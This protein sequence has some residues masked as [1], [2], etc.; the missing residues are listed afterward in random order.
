[1]IKKPICEYIRNNDS[2][3]Y[4][5]T[6]Q[7]YAVENRTIVNYSIEGVFDLAVKLHINKNT[8]YHVS[9]LV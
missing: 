7:D 1:M 4:I 5:H 3:K 9:N 2:C 8:N 6:I